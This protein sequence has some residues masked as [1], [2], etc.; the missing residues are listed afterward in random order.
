MPIANRGPRALALRAGFAAAIPA[1]YRPWR[2]VGGNLGLVAFAGVGLVAG[3]RDVSV[4]EWL[5]LPCTFVAM[6]LLEYGSHRWLMHRKRRWAGFVY[7]AHTLRH[8]ASFTETHMAIESDRE[9]GLIVFGLREIAGF[10]FA[11]LPGL[12]LVVGLVS[13]NAGLLAAAMVCVH[14]LLYEGLHLVAHLPDDHW[15]ARRPLLASARRR[16][17]RH[18]G[19][20]GADFNVTMPL[21]DGLFGTTGKSRRG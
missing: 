11:T 21:A 4:A 15:L 20:A 1:S 3:L 5:A 19:A 6:N 12:A 2:H 16:H 8:H 13:R 7:D 14:Y 10:V 9:I 18:H 17:A